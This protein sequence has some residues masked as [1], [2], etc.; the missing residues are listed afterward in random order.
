MKV[1]KHEK[2]KKI[3]LQKIGGNKDGTIKKVTS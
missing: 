2:K 3:S 1:Q